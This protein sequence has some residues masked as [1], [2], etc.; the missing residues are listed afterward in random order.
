MSLKGSLYEAMVAW[1]REMQFV[2]LS[3]RDLT[4]AVKG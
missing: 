4:W 2:E 1:P 3:A